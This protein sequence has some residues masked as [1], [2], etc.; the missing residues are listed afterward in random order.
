MTC[1][2]PSS[3]IAEEWPA[4]DCLYGSSS[5]S[6]APRR[7]QRPVSA[8]VAAVCSLALACS[9]FPWSEVFLARSGQ[10][11]RSQIERA[12]CRSVRYSTN[13]QMPMEPG[14]S[15]YEEGYEQL[16]TRWNREE[17][18]AVQNSKRTLQSDKTTKEAKLLAINELEYWAIRR[19]GYDAE[20]ILIGALKYPDPVLAGQAHIS[21]KKTWQ[22]HFNMWVNNDIDSGRVLQNRGKAAEALPIF[23]KV[24]YENPIWGEGYH[25]RAKCWNMLNETGKVIEDLRKALEFCPN[26][27]LVMV[28][29]AVTLM[30]KKQQYEEAAELFQHATDLCPFLPVDVFLS[31]LY[32]KVPHLKEQHEAE[33][34]AANE[35]SFTEPP[36]RLLPDAWVNRFEA[37]ERPNQAFLRV[38]AELEQWF[39][40]VRENKADSSTQRK[41]WS[42]L[43]IKWDPDKHP[44]ALRSFCTQVHEALKSRRERELAKAVAPSQAPA[45]RDPDEEEMEYAADE[46]DEEA[47][48][49]LR[50]LR[51]ERKRR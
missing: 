10:L 14:R 51:A 28:E 12:R 2:N 6:T 30:D 3:A 35:F 40:Q 5:C 20:I 42:R 8:S 50:H 1:V 32:E 33:K 18:E 37:T 17:A 13:P 44:R 48:A 24:I 22:N 41:L 11:S 27:Y 29:L 21:L 4:L 25:L 23:D 36:A 26:N 49:F 46:Y 31:G 43:V 39:A 16:C 9:A 47:V 38:G 19:G 34:E 45:P 7:R 15:S